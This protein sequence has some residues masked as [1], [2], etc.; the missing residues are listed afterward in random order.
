VSKDLRSD[1]ARQLLIEIVLCT[2]CN[3]STTKSETAA[4]VPSHH[5]KIYS[6]KDSEEFL[7]TVAAEN[8]LKYGTIR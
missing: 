3:S 5:A 1:T 6:G 8:C 2:K 7:E 4:A